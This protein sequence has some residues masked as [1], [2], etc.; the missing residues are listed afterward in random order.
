VQRNQSIKTTKNEHQNNEI[1]EEKEVVNTNKEI[2]PVETLIKE[3]IKKGFIN[4]EEEIEK[5]FPIVTL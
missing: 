4:E 5:S 1:Y 2:F 3:K